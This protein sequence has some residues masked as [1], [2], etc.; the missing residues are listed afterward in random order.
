M[1]IRIVSA[2]RCSIKLA[3]RTA[4]NCLKNLQHDIKNSVFHVFG[5]HAN[6]STFCKASAGVAEMDTVDDCSEGDNTENPDFV[7][8]VMEQQASYWADGMSSSALDEA[9]LGSKVSLIE[10]SM[11]RLFKM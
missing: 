7:G 6:C 9:R 2:V 11:V 4:P 5:Y 1:R 8:S 10:K 3:D